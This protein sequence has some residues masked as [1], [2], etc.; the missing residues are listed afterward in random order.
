MQAEYPIQEVEA[1]W[2]PTDAQLMFL[3]AGVT[4]NVH[5]A[6]RWEKAPD[7]RILQRALDRLVERHAMLRT[8]FVTGA[9]GTVLAVTYAAGSLPIHTLALESP[10]SD[11]AWEHARA[12]AEALASRR[13][14]AATDRL[15]RLTVAP[16]PDGSAL[17]VLVA[18]HSICDARSCAILVAELGLLHLAM[19]ARRELVLPAI[20]TTYFEHVQ[21]KRRWLESEAAQEHVRY[22][23]EQFARM[24][25]PCV[26]VGSELARDPDHEGTGARPSKGEIAG[27]SVTGIRT[28]VAEEDCTVFVAVAAAL[29]LTLYGWRRHS[30]VGLWMLQ[31]GRPTPELSRVFGLFPDCWMLDVHIEP[32]RSVRETI[33]AAR[34]RYIDALPHIH[35]PATIAAGHLH[36]EELLKSPSVIVNFLPFRRGSAAG[37][38]LGIT[39]V[40]L[41]PGRAELGADPG[42]VLLVTITEL[43]DSIR[44]SIR[45][46]PAQVTRDAVE[47]VSGNFANVLR[48]MGTDAEVRVDALQSIS[49]NAR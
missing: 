4:H 1:T 42:I 9:D 8:R 7:V 2:A 36:D 22:W 20:G 34:E 16:M 28:L 6:W 49:D 43:E 47:H 37:A 24:H 11:A 14:D 17:L 41:L 44:W 38:N 31:E 12:H 26:L 48:S 15:A 13:F 18:H 25:D 46:S 3:T 27:P 45:H 5:Q 39:N 19:R 21:A 40:D 30:D 35:V 33:R 10:D 23:R 32:R 29:M